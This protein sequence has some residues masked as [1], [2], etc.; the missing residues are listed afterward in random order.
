MEFRYS[1]G[2]F[3]SRVEPGRNF[4]DVNEKPTDCNGH[5][6]HVAA[7]LAGLNVGVT[8]ETSII[9]VKVLDCKKEV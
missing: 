2:A 8:S 5:G 4:V 1:E 7:I 6:T 3:G 9:P